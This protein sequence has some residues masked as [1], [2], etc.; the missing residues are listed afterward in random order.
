MNILETIL[1][2]TRREIT[3]AKNSVPIEKLKDM[4]GFIR[5]CFSFHSALQN[6]DVAV[7]AELKKASP[8]KGI[9]R[10]DFDPLSLAKEYVDSGAS[11]LSVLTDSKFFQGNI[12][13]IF[14]IRSSV[15]IPILRK[16]FIIDSYQII[17]AKAFGADAILLIAA[18]LAPNQLRDLHEEAAEVGLDCLVEVHHEQE[19]EKLAQTQVKIIGINN[20]D[21][22][23]F[24][25][26]ISTT[27]RI[28]SRV[29]P[30]IT[31][32]SESGIMKRADID[33]LATHGIHAVLVGESLMKAQKPGDALKKL[34]TPSGG[35][36]R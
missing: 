2:N 12:R 25:V 6:D 7:I 10:D 11:A 31:L 24:T 30:G 5:R 23:D 35:A 18:A 17:E 20:R 4:P 3:H 27:L 19:L 21:L 15:P 22:S 13:Y 1:D 32:V 9:L 14:D 26:D 16:D 28:A 33:Y 34:L 8:S 36:Y 29:P